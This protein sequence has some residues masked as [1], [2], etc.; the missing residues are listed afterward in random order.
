M[1]EFSA[2]WN[3]TSVGDATAAPYDANTEF[4]NWSRAIIGYGA[5]RNNSGVL[6]GSGSEAAQ[7]E[8]VQ[9][10]ANSPAAMNVLVNIGNALVHGTWYANDSALTLTVA[11]NASGNPRIDTIVLRKTWA[12]QQVRAAI[13]TGTPAASPVPPNLTQSDGTTWEIPLADIAVANGAVSITNL[14]ITPR[15]EPTN[16]SDGV[17]LDRLLN[18]SGT[19]LANGTV[20]GIDTSANRAANTTYSHA[21]R[22]PTIRVGTWLARTAAAGF[23]RIMNSGIGN[24]ATIAAARGTFLGGRGTASEFPQFDTFAQL[25]EAASGTGVVPAF[26]SAGFPQQFGQILDTSL[27]AAPTA[28]FSLGGGSNSFNLGY[29]TLMVEYFLRSAVAATN[30]NISV[31]FAGDNTAGNYRTYRLIASGTVPT[32]AA[33]E[34]IGTT[35]GLQLNVPGSTATA[36]AYA[37]GFLFISNVNVSGTYERHMVGI[38]F[39][40]ITNVTGGF[41]VNLFGGLWTAVGTAFTTLT[42][43][44]N[45]G[46][47]FETGS[48][49]NVFTKQ[50]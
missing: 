19:V 11:A 24:I 12:S 9:V 3:G 43:N 26:L 39:Y 38:Q 29:R 6:Y 4:A 28:G 1:T 33:V 14:N 7:L 35:A 34:N 16:V 21:T 36:G 8:G 50:V 41:I 15:A 2:F 13:L 25:L 47:N 45:G 37:H 20:V 18:N 27:L 22:P 48:Y 46:S 30:D 31:R 42:V 5:N 17:Y 23:G 32:M 40:R 10:T 44:S 49:V